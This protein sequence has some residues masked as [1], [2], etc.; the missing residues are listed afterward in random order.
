MNQFEQGWLGFLFAGFLFV[1][2]LLTVGAIVI[3]SKVSLPVD[4]YGEL[5]QSLTNRRKISAES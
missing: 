1:W 4:Q 5:Q 3:V 2:D